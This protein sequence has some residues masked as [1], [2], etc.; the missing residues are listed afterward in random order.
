MGQAGLVRVGVALLRDIAIRTPDFG[1]M[2]IHHV[3]DHNGAPC[4]RGLVDHSL[5]A[6]EHP[7]VSVATLDAN[8]GLVR[9]DHLG[10]AQLGDGDRST[11]FEAALR[12]AQHVHQTALADLKTKQVSEGR[13]K[14]LVGQRLEGLQIGRHRVQLR[15]KRRALGRRRHT[16]CPVDGDIKTTR[17]CCEAPSSLIAAATL[18]P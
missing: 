11:V 7:M 14:P 15:P 9:A 18:E 13:L 2:P 16:I 17:E 12:A 8:A 10:L 1:A 4:R 3:A 6:A 5:G